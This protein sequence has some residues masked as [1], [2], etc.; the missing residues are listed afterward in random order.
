M[1]D[2]GAGG[3]GYPEF[4]DGVA[5]AEVFNRHGVR[6]VLIG[7]YVAQAFVADYCSRAEIIVTYA[8]WS[9]RPA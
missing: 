6:Y 7:G 5:L 1:S 8:T 2:P 4:P 9:G 3:G